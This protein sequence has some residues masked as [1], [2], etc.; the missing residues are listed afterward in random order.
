MKYYIVAGEASGDLHGSNLMKG[1]YKED[2]QATIRFW[3]GP[4]MDAVYRDHENGEGMVEDYRAGAVMGVVEVLKKGPQ[5]ESPPASRAHKPLQDRYHR[6]E[7]GCSHSHRLPR[8]QLQGG[9]VCP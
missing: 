3:G 4:L 1:L 5:L 2:P 9:R 7:P 6:L 8:L